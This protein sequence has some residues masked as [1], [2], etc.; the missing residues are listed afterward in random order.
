MI[1]SDGTIT[2]YNLKT[3]F[4]SLGDALIHV[5]VAASRQVPSNLGIWQVV[6]LNY[7]ETVC[8]VSAPI[9]RPK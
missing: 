2:R 4:L 7:M 8:V 1:T 6:I 9:E 3:L 5:V